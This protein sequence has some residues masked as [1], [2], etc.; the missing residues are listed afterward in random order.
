MS[1]QRGSGD[2]EPTAP[3]HA[4]SDEKAPIKGGLAEGE[5]QSD[6]GTKSESLTGGAPEVG[7]IT[8]EAAEERAELA[9][10][11]PTAEVIAVR[12]GMFGV[13][14]S[15]DTSGYG[16]LRRIVEFPA[17]SLPPFGGWWDQ[18]YERLRHLMGEGGVPFGLPN[19][20]VPN[21]SEVVTKVVIH[22]GEITFHVAREHLPMLVRH[23]R[24]DAHLRF[25][26][27][28]SVSGV[29][30]PDD[31]GRELHAVYHLQSMTHNRR[32]R[33]E[34]SAPDS[35][36]HIPSVVA[37]YPTA[38]WHERETWDM[39]GI[40]FDGHPALTRILM[41][42]DWPGHPQRKD[43]PLGGIPVEYKGGTIPPA[44]QRRSYS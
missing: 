15:G 34:V 22:R 7:S 18:V 27:C 33:L 6:A 40:I 36:P 23:L 14:G 16:G 19:A 10:V 38:D 8:P 31:V 11:E 25:E 2:P 41:P 37:V 32:I 35:D 28:S 42:D 4:E 12:K 9:V 21:Y 5:S 20:L 43:Y 39:F 3:V 30:Y 26:F 17:P 24:D 13:K 44:D 29:H 1:E